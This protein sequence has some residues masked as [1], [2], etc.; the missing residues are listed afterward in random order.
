MMGIE[1][2]KQKSRNVAVETSWDKFLTRLSD[3]RRGL[4]IF[5]E[6]IGHFYGSRLHFTNHHHTN[7]SVIIHVAR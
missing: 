6:Y 2:W 3:Y 7:T 1:K 4:G 5:I